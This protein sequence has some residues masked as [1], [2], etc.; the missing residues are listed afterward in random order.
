MRY[1]NFA[2]TISKNLDR[3]LHFELEGLRL[4]KKL[5]EN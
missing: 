2:K 1:N 4:K 5:F 3:T